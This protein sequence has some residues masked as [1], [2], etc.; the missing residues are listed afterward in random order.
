MHAR[1]RTRPPIEGMNRPFSGFQPLLTGPNTLVSASSFRQLYTAASRRDIQRGPLHV[2]AISGRAGI[3]CPAGPLTQ[4]Q[5]PAKSC[6]WIQSMRVTAGWEA[7]RRALR[8]LSGPPNVTPTVPSN[9]HSAN[10]SC[11]RETHW[12]G[13]KLPTQ[14][15]QSIGFRSYVQWGI[16]QQWDGAER[17]NSH[18]WG[19]FLPLS[20][21]LFDPH[22]DCFCLADG[23]HIPGYQ[24]ESYLEAKWK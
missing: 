14:T 16:R 11:W 8:Q 21:V 19:R 18:A 12:P 13:S 23:V 5:Q 24:R 9:Y 2:C 10:I 6:Q 15:I 20:G 7:L 1:I 4:R 3:P 22:H 17:I